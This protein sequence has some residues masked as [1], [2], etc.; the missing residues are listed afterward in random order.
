VN[1]AH[2]TAFTWLRWRMMVNHWRRA[3]AFSAALMIVVAISLAISAIPLFLGGFALAMFLI[4]KA[5][6]AQ[7]M[8]AWDVLIL[9]FLLFWAIGLL[10]ELQRNDPLSLSKFLHLPVSV[11]GAFLINYFSSLF[12]LSLLFFFP[13]MAAF[14]LALIYV[15]GVSQLVVLP[16]LA[17][18]LLMITAP[19]YQFQGWL[20]SLM[21]N[22]RRRRAVVV[23]T[24]MAFVLVFQLPN[25]VHLYTPK[26]IERNNARTATHVAELGRLRQSLQSKEIDLPEFTRRQDEEMARFKAEGEKASR[27][28]VAR[29]EGMARVANTAVPLGWLPLGVM[30]AAKGQIAPALLGMAGMTLIGTISLWRAYRTT[31]GQFQGQASNRKQRATARPEA[32]DHQVRAGGEGGTEVKVRGSLLEA[33]IPGLSEPVSAIALGGFRSLLRSPEAKISLLTPLIM[34]GIFGSMLL[35]GGS[36]TPELLRPMFGIAAIAFVLFGLLQLMG[37]QF[38]MDRDGFRVFVL[39]AAPRREILLGKNLAFA[40]PAVILSTIMLVAIQILSPMR[41]DHA[42]AMIPQFVSMFLLFSAM[43]NLFSICAPVFIAA[44]TLKPANPKFSTVMLQLVMFLFLFPICQGVTMIPLGA[45]AAMRAFGWSESLPIC[46]LL[47]L[48]ECAVVIL[49]YHLSLGW[50]GA[51]LQSREQKILETVTN[52]AL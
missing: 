44:G 35:R 37:N 2:L 17:A 24:T 23:G 15:Q 31:L 6:P 18:F 12:R 22:P 27:E 43:A 20:A 36:S 45:E 26:L 13:P 33:R 10:T 39:C 25:L 42:V 38:G 16:A 50:L 51:L 14:A 34:G 21:N 52:R 29:W 8:Y 48:A 32:D 5:S 3:G 46:L 4:P 19:T 28:E 40:P 49:F 1:W 9:A 11:N 7:L 47:T 30:S 41:V